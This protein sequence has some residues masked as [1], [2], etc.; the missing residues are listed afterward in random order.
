[1]FEKFRDQIENSAIESQPLLT[2]L[3]LK[4]SLQEKIVWEELREK[5]SGAGIET[6][7][8]DDDTIA[9]QT[10]PLLLKNIEKVVRSLLAGSDAPR[11][12][13]ASLARRACKASIVA[14][15]KLD[16]SQADYQRKQLLECK[17]PF[18]CPHGRPTL[19][20]VTQGFLDRQFLRS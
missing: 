3:L 14:G 1:M 19:I 4:L 11:M 7:K 17:D 13:H 10:Q 9:V 18:T 6:T 12:D 16:I 8:F 20:E 5:L 15:D 2:P